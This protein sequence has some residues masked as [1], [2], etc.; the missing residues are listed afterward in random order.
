MEESIVRADDEAAE[1]WT[2]S[3][4]A[5]LCGRPAGPALGTPVALVEASRALAIKIARRSERL[6]D[7]VVVDPLALMAERAGLVGLSKRGTSSCGG[8][9]R[10]MRAVDGWVALTLG[11]DEDWYLLDALFGSSISIPTGHWDAVQDAVAIR[12]SGQLRDQATLLGLPLA[13]LND[14]QLTR[15]REPDTDVPGSIHGISSTMVGLAART[16]AI[17]DL[18]VADLSTLWAGPTVGRLLSI[19]GATVV[20]IESTSRP[21][22]ARF[23]DRQFFDRLNSEK[24]S[25]AFDFT[26]GRGRRL[27]HQFVAQSDI[28]IT[29]CRNRALAQ[30]GLDPRLVLGSCRPRAWIRISGY[31]TT[32]GARDRVAFGDDAAVAGGL[33]LWDGSI[34]CFCGDAVADPLT[35]LAVTATVLSALDH[36]GTWIIDASM[37]DIAAGT[38]GPVKLRSERLSEPRPTGVPPID[39]RS[40]GSSPQL[41]SDTESLL[42]AMGIS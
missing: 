17:R 26:S 9:T 13:A 15:R 41:G 20:K 40:L 28:V 37:A 3:G 4:M 23:G 1:L 34:P 35:G 39:E 18:V 14:H 30:L 22:G 27:L 24:F 5:S 32:P 7:A 29:S 19:A 10:L 38:S 25:V 12:S 11:R 16:R 33:V 2:S 31:G 21:D 36:G 8:G 42:A 6:G